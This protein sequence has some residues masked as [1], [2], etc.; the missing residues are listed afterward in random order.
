MLAPTGGRCP[1]RS[2]TDQDSL[3]RLSGMCPMSLNRCAALPDPT[4][5]ALRIAPQYR[6]LAEPA[7]V[8]AI[9][10]IRGAAAP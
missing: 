4:R 5:Q 10:R 3:I 2:A 9:E 8:V 6:D 1:S 7:G